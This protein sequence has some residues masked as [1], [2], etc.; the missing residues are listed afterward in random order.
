MADYYINSD[1]GKEIASS[2][3]AGD[4]RDVSDGSTWIKNSDGSFTILKNGQKMNGQVGVSPSADSPNSSAADNGNP[5]SDATTSESSSRS[6]LYPSAESVFGKQQ[7]SQA[8]KP[9]ASEIA[10]NATNAVTEGLYTI[11][12]ELGLSY[13]NSLKNAG[14][15]KLLSDGYTLKRE[16]D[17]SYSVTKGDS[18]A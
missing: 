2:M 17:G 14:D 13:V 3:K 12:T 5:S 7:E 18:S 8:Q 15:T 1:K 9:S 6:P 10:K 4:V 16:N 11:G